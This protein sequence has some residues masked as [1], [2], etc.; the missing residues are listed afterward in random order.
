VT[1]VNEHNRFYQLSPSWSVEELKHRGTLGLEGSV[2]LA[3]EGRILA[4][5]TLWDQRNY[6]QTVIRGYSPALAFARPA[7]NVA[8]WILGHSGLP[9]PNRILANA[10]TTQL[11]AEPG[12]PHSL[13]DMI[14]LLRW[15]ASQ[16]GIE[17]L[18]IGFASDDPR[19]AVV[20][21]N[22]R[23]REYLTRLYMVRWPEFGGSAS[24]LDRRI[25]APEVALL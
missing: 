9:A 20:R 10:F 11:V 15:T 13:T 1:R 16:R 19:L 21:S 25:L 14:N 22:F 7:V 5:A 17:F 3:S 18:T 2:T 4:S 6:K 23:R 24:E 8:A 12:N